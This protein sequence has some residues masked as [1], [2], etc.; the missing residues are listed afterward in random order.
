[1]KQVFKNGFMMF[2]IVLFGT[3][4]WSFDHSINLEKNGKD[5]ILATVFAPDHTSSI[6]F[7]KE[8]SNNISLFKHEFDSSS[9]SGKHFTFNYDNSLLLASTSYCTLVNV[10]RYV[11][12]A[13]QSFNYL[14]ILFRKLTI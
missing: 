6:P 12:D 5:Q 2:F 3:V 1:M 4:I 7:L 9:P 11:P 10:G 14:Y 13:F 8:E